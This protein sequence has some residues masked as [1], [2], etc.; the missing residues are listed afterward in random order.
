[1]DPHRIE[2]LDRAHDNEGAGRIT[3]DLELEFLPPENRR[4]DQYL[5]GGRRLEPLLEQ[6]FEALPIVGDAAAPTAE[7]EGGAEDN[8]QVD[9][10]DGLEALL[11]RAHGGCGQNGQPG[12]L[13]RTAEGLAILGEADRLHRG[14][15]Q[16]NSE[17]LEHPRLLEFDRQIE[18][19]LAAE[20]GDEGVGPLLFENRRYRLCGQR[21]DIGA[22]GEPRIGH[23][24][25]GIGVHQDD[26]AAL[27]A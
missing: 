20:G 27:L 7:G 4:L 26:P 19:G 3:H 9:G 25:R 21:L 12:L 23:H 15:E 13:H 11:N 16:A 17:A 14:A 24:R 2:V 8:R 1:M 6:E 22:M 5:V 10:L 18:G